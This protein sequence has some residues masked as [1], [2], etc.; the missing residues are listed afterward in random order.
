M[1]VP[2]PA[3]PPAIRGVNTFGET[4][5]QLGLTH[6]GLAKDHLLAAA[7]REAGLHAFGSDG[8]REGLVHP[9]QSPTRAASRSIASIMG[10]TTPRIRR[11]T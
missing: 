11:L 5:A 2:C 10:S 9:R 1:E 7:R 8:F 6:P 4:A 3:R